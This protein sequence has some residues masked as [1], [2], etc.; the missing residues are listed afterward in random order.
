MQSKQVISCLPPF[1]LI[2]NAGDHFLT[3]VEVGFAKDV[4]E[5]FKMTL[6]GNLITAC[7]CFL[8]TNVGLGP[9]FTDALGILDHFTVIA[10]A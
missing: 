1:S 3:A 8:H 5:K 10:D 6:T 2:E 9:F 7:A 4:F